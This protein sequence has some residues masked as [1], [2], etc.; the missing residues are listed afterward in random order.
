M[1]VDNWW[2]IEKQGNPKLWE[3]MGR[4][5]SQPS[6]QSPFAVRNIITGET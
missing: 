6:P 5:T 4:Y 3:V 1:F 2:T